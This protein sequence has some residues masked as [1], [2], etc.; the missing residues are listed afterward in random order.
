MKKTKLLAYLSISFLICGCESGGAK[1]IKVQ[2]INGPVELHTQAQLDFFNNKFYGDNVTTL[3]PNIKGQE[4]LS[5]PLPVKLD[6]EN[7]NC[8]KGYRV[9]ISE[10]E[11]LDLPWTYQTNE[12]KL[13]VYNLK[14]GTTYY[15]QVEE[16]KENGKKSEVKSFTTKE[17]VRNLYIDGVTNVRDFVIDSNVRSIIIKG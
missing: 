16:N 1:A 12:D 2:D 6:W 4:E 9:T 13:D 14:T 11:T 8:E 5:R 10:Y 17:G 7:T 3:D 15:Y